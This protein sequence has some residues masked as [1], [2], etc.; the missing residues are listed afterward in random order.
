[1]GSDK[2]A[3]AVDGEPLLRRVLDSVSTVADEVLVVESDHSPVPAA[4]LTGFAVRLVRDRWPDAGPLAGLEAGLRACDAPL[5]IVVGADA[6]YLQPALLRLLAHEL[7]AAPEADA[8]AVASGR[9]AE[10]LL[11]AYRPRV[12]V[13]ATSMLAAG[14]RRL[15]TLFERIRTVVLEPPAWW[16][17]DPDGLS[18]RNAN[19]VADLPGLTR[20][21]NNEPRA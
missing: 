13:A 16:G 1:M 9:G 10:P 20:S 11:A 15:G 7:A 17:A 19:S 8:V 3:L 18:L 4:L 5:A 2:R 21:A 14:E 6:P 12:A